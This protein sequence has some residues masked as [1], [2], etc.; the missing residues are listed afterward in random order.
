MNFL[1]TKWHFYW[2]KFH[3]KWTCV[4]MDIDDDKATKHL[5]K[6]LHHNK[7]MCRNAMPALDAYKAVLLAKAF[8]DE[9]KA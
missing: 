8:P 6:F 1:L 9:T 4:Y 3:L 7:W 2:L 5:R